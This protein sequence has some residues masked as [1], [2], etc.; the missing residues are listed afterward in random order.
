MKNPGLRKAILLSSCL[1]L[2][3]SKTN[4]ANRFWVAT[5]PSNWNN[6]ANWS[7]VSGG[8]G[9]S[10]V[11][12][13]ADAAIFDNNGAGNCTIDIAVTIT[14]VN[15]NATYI[16]TISQGANTITTSGTATFSG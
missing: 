2:L 16:G 11:P 14:S 10:S 3:I 6:T 13:A 8:A 5:G 7:I 4:A 15:V 1:L 9:G 12:G